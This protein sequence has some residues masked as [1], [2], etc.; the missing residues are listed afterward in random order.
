MGMRSIP[1]L[2]EYVKLMYE[3]CPNAWLINFANPAG[4]LTEAVSK[5]ARWKTELSAFVM[6]P[7]LC[8]GLP[9]NP[10]GLSQAM[11]I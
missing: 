6:L 1:V 7:H 2:L 11:Y 8:I 5:I 10:G 4:M 9:V 3:V